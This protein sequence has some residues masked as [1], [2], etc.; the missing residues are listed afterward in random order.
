MTHHYSSA[1]SVETSFSSQSCLWALPKHWMSLDILPDEKR[2]YE[3]KSKSIGANFTSPAPENCIKLHGV[4]SKPSYP[5]HI[6]NLV[7][8][9]WSLAKLQHSI[10][11]LRCH[12]CLPKP[13]KFLWS[14]RL[15][16]F[17]GSF[18]QRVHHTQWTMTPL[19]MLYKNHPSWAT[20][21]MPRR[22]KQLKDKEQ[23]KD[24]Q[25]HSGFRFLVSMTRSHSRHI[26]RL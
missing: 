22:F 19:L 21:N 2:K 25:L 4:T 13:C 24:Y 18:P 9:E 14:Q 11:F 17:T 8:Q 15:D 26:C 3:I 10:I 1:S 6:E 23:S 16:S 5:A 20:S 7:P 12:Q